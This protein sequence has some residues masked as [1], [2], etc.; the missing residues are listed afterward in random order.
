MP[1]RMLYDDE[2]TPIGIVAQSKWLKLKRK[3][4]RARRVQEE[5]DVVRED[6][7]KIQADLKENHPDEFKALLRMNGMSDDL[8]DLSEFGDILC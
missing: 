5:L 1:N 7:E 2:P 8:N 3:E 4:A 6:W